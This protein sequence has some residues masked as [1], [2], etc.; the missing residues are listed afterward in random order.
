MI[1]LSLRLADDSD[2]E[3]CEQLNRRMGVWGLQTQYQLANQLPPLP[4]SALPAADF[5]STAID[6]RPRAS[7]SAAVSIDGMPRRGRSG[8]M[9]ITSAP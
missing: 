1:A 9:R 2:R 3:F 6:A 7:T 5:R 4:A 8:W